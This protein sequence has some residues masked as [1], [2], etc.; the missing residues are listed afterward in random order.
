MPLNAA[1]ECVKALQVKLTELRFMMSV[2]SPC[3]A[4]VQEGDEDDSCVYL[5]S[6]GIHLL[7]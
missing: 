7:Y 6:R 5:V 2:Q 1:D 3:L 4:A